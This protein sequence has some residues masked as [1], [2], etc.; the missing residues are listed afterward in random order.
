MTEAPA[1]P[2][3]PRW[4]NTTV[5]LVV[6]AATLG[7]IYR[8]DL[9]YR[10]WMKRN[11]PLSGPKARVDRAR[12]RYRKRRSSA[13]EVVQFVWALLRMLPGAATMQE[14]SKTTPT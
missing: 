7:I 14:Q 5:T 10:R 3:L 6:C 11:D 13:T 12:T 8:G 9:A 4:L 1:P 2:V